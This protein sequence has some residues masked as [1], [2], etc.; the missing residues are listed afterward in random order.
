MAHFGVE[1]VNLLREKHLPSFLVIYAK[2]KEQGGIVFGQFPVKV[3]LNH[4]DYHGG[5]RLN[6]QEVRLDLSNSINE[7]TAKR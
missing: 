3:N 7:A 2:K 1:E 6:T 4:I 5:V